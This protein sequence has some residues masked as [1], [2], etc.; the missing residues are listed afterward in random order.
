MGAQADSDAGAGSSYVSTGHLPSPDLVT[1]ARDRAP[2]VA[3]FQGGVGPAQKEN[4]TCGD[5][6]G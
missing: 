3:D 2:A 6:V 5:A 1:G 4:T